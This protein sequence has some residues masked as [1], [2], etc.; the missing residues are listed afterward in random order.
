MLHLCRLP[1]LSLYYKDSGSAC[2]NNGNTEQANQQPGDSA[3][4]NTLNLSG[5]SNLSL[6]SQISDEDARV[7]III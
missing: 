2:N 3:N 4:N 7:N 1:H 6:L 5:F